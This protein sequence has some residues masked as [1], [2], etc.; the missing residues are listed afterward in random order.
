M[1]KG[2]LVIRAKTLEDGNAFLFPSGQKKIVSINMLVWM[3]SIEKFG[4]EITEKN[5]T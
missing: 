5:P 3:P 1:K 4:T 2:N